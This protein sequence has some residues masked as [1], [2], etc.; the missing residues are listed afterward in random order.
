MDPLQR[1]YNQIRFE[2]MKVT[3]Y[4]PQIDIT[5]P[6]GQAYSTIVSVH[7]S[8]LSGL[9]LDAT[10]QIQANLSTMNSQ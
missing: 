9:K 10:L 1:I 3:E 8:T 6:V 7:K 2:Q 5:T 4:S